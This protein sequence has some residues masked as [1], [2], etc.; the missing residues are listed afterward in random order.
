MRNLKEEHNKEI[1]ELKNEIKNLK[2]EH[3]KEI[4]KL[5]EAYNNEVGNLKE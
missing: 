4:N 3:N 1:N 5:K 2:E